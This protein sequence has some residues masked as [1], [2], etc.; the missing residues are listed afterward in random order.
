MRKNLLLF[1]IILFFNGFSAHSQE[2]DGGKKFSYRSFSVSPLGVYFGKS[3]GLYVAGDISF[4]YGKHVFSLGVGSGIEGNLFGKSEEFSEFNFTYGQSFPLN[5]K[6]FADVYVGAGYFQYS[7][8]GV[9]DDYTGRRGEIQE[10]T[11]GFPIGAKFQY[12]LG[13]RFSMGLRVGA[14]VNAAKSIGTLGLVFQWNKKR[15]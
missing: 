12:M 7:S 4:D 6:L 8:V 13:Q 1:A 9:I 10:S 15:N 2:V 5:E 11:I 3:S 14:N